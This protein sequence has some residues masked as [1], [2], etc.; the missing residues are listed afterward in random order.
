M[1]R[2]KGKQ[3]EADEDG[4]CPDCDAPWEF[5]QCYC[6]IIYSDE[7]IKRV[8]VCSERKDKTN[9]DKEG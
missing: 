3:G 4:Y 8:P 1:A 2:K 7:E 6:D 9:L 5:C